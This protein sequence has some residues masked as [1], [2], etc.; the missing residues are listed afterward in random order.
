MLNL[1]R[2]LFRGRKI[3]EIPKVGIWMFFYISRFLLIFW[4]LCL[5]T[6]KQLD[7]PAVYYVIRVYLPSGLCGQ[8]LYPKYN[9][10]SK[11]STTF[12]V[13]G[14]IDPWRKYCIFLQFLVLFSYFYVQKSFGTLK[15]LHQKLDKPKMNK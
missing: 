15:H 8:V 1:S 11:E 5:K 3:Y 2:G 14:Q 10:N 9:T 4:S 6:S 7:L 13:V 12:A